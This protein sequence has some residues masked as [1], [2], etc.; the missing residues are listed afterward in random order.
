M[1]ETKPIWISASQINTFEKCQRHWWFR[2][3]MKLP[4]PP[5]SHF[6]F[7]TVL[8]AVCERYL[9]ADDQ[10]RVPK[11]VP[12]A[13]AMQRPG[14]PVDLY[15]KLVR[16]IY[17]NT[18]PKTGE[19][20]SNRCFKPWTQT[21]ERDGSVA[22]VT[23][24]EAAYI[25][26]LI[27][28][29]IELGILE[30]SPNVQ[31]E[32]KLE[33]EVLPAEDDNPAVWLVGYV[34]V[35]R[36]AVHGRKPVV[37][38][39]KSFGNARYIKKSK[40]SSPHYLGNDQ[41][42]KTYAT[43]ASKLDGYVGPVDVRHNQF[44]KRPGR[45]VSRA[46][47]TITVEQQAEHWKYL[48]KVADAIREAKKVT[49]FESLPLPEDETSCTMW[50]GKACPFASICSGDVK[51]EHYIDQVLP[52]LSQGAAPPRGKLNLPIDPLLTPAQKRKRQAER[53]STPMGLMDSLPP[54]PGTSAASASPPAAPQLN[55]P[56]APVTATPTAAPVVTS[57]KIGSLPPWAKPGC[58]ACGTTTHPGYNNLGA[59]CQVCD[60]LAGHTKDRPQ[61]SMYELQQTAEGIRTATARQGFE[62]AIQALGGALEWSSGTVPTV[63]PPAPAPDVAQEPAPA[64]VATPEPEIVPQEVQTSKDAEKADQEAQKINNQRR[65][66]EQQHRR[67]AMEEDDAP[68][69]HASERPKTKGKRG[70]PKVGV[71]LLIGCSVIQGLGKACRPLTIQ[72]VLARV[73]ADIAERSGVASY[74]QLDAFRRREVFVAEAAKIAEIY[75]TQFIWC[76]A[77]M[78]PDEKALVG[79]LCG[80]DEN[81][82]IIQAGA[83]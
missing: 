20:H 13:L 17:Y 70:R 69:V 24:N 62:P 6:T 73:G 50:Y 5:A 59:A 64:P 44:P 3:V 75:N 56:A 19:K 83:I 66:E 79:A 48:L 72:Q 51:P 47:A 67:L 28:E 39:F 58:D 41:Q 80:L 30:R 8:H 53:D 65:M 21:V 74:Y 61:S 1:T 54:T 35:F 27:T 45:K 16:H 33:V 63:A 11:P 38:D 71:T 55:P 31:P 2:R 37:E 36:P 4:E 76:P 68:E 32:R 46:E 81:V 49:D 10:G 23:P 57:E 29:A 26:K 77:H 52:Q 7:G 40:P 9:S 18:D 34:D 15:P 43:I 22:E 12:P 42:I 60:F 82:T 78:G 25:Q 14:E